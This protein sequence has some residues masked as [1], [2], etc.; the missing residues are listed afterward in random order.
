MY[1]GVKNTRPWFQKSTLWQPTNP[2]NRKKALHYKHLD[3]D[4]RGWNS[5][6]D[7]LPVSLNV[8]L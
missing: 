8:L 4:I 5:L 2:K 1:L 3:T 7:D 6:K